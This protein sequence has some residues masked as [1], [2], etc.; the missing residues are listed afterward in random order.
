M[1]KIKKASK[2]V[3]EDFS[4][5]TFTFA[6]GRALTVEMIGLN[7]ELRRRGLVHGISQKVGDSYAS[8][9]TI[10]EAYEAA[11]DVV[12][13]LGRGEWS[14]RTV[15]GGAGKPTILIEA[16]FRII[17][18]E[19]KTLQDATDLIN[20]MSDEQREGLRRLAP[21]VAAV[22]AIKLE[23]LSEKAKKS[24]AATAG[25]TLDLSAVMGA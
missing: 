14:S 4:A 24:A 2:T 12:E 13:S 21:I 25:Q 9:E 18:A 10:D 17:Q 3:A 8:A 5:V 19:G 15:G 6:D 20:E 7:D 22:D 23:R 1:A 16:L 11:A